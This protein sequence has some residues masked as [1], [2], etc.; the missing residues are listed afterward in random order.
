MPL[1]DWIDSTRIPA[2]LFPDDKVRLWDELRDFPRGVNYFAS[3]PLAVEFLQGDAWEGF[4]LLDFATGNRKVVRGIILS[5]TCD[6]SPENSRDVPPN[7]VFAP[8]V[9]LAKYLQLLSDNGKSKQSTNSFLETL[10][11]Q[12]ITSAFYIP[13]AEGVEESI[14]L[15]DQLSSHPFSHFNST[16]RR[17]LFR[18]G[19]F[20]HYLL[21]IKL[22][23]HFCRFQ[24]KVNRYGGDVVPSD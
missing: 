13:S 11:R 15:F 12:E 7:V 18:L 2:Y 3:Q 10:K 16:T 20:G 23:I 4:E 1:D 24:E 17:I 9:N 19:Q 6:I 14:V 8:I 22:S 21:L 5:N